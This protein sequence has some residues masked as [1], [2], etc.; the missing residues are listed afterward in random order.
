MR[1]H[2]IT[3]TTLRAE[4]LHRLA[5]EEYCTLQQQAAYMLDHAIEHAIK[6]HDRARESA[7]EEYLEVADE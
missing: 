3:L 7:R 4:Q 1:L 6:A 5:M 2:S